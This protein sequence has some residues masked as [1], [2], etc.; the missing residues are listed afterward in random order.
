MDFY[1]TL[2]V[3]DEYAFSRSKTTL[4]NK[5]NQLMYV[6]GKY[7]IYQTESGDYDLINCPDLIRYS[8]YKEGAV[9]S[10]FEEIGELP[11]VNIKIIRHLQNISDNRLNIISCSINADTNEFYNYLIYDEEKETYF[12][13]NK[14]ENIEHLKEKIPN[15]EGSMIYPVKI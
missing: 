2:T 7:A 4:S 15:K 12:T 14:I 1:N 8:E 3:N 9:P 10:D 5:K 11:V 13:V 6:V